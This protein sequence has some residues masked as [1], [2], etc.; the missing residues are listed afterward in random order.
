MNRPARFRLLT[1]RHRPEGVAAISESGHMQICTARRRP[2][3]RCGVRNAGFDY[4]SEKCG[5]VRTSAAKRVFSSI[6]TEP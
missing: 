3:L 1:S 5:C 2:P 4:L 6:S